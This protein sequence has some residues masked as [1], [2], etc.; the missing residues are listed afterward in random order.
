VGGAGAESFDLADDYA[1]AGM[2]HPLLAAYRAREIARE[3]DATDADHLEDC[4]RCR[5]AWVEAGCPVWANNTIRTFL[6]ALSAEGGPY[7]DPAAPPEVW[8]AWRA[9]AALTPKD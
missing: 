6:S 4:D 8:A 9:L 1:G 7:I 5:D 3:S 2:I